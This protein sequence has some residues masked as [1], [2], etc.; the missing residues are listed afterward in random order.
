MLKIIVVDDE[1]LIRKGLVKV[2]SNFKTEFQVLGEATNGLEAMELIGREIPDVVITDVKMPH[3]D[4]VELVKE[5]ERHYP[6]IKKIVISGFGEFDYVR[7]T[8]RYGALDYLLKPLDDEQLISLLGKIT[9]FIE[10]DKKQRRAESNL[11]EKLNE[12]LPFLK[13]QFIFELI[14]TSK[15]N[16]DD[17]DQKL[18]LYEIKLNPGKY[19]V[20]I[21][22]LD[23]YRWICREAGVEATKGMLLK[24]KSCFDEVLGRCYEP[25]SCPFPGGQIY[26]IST[27]TAD[28]KFIQDVLKEGL[29]SLELNAPEIRVTLSI[30]PPCDDL[31]CLMKSYQQA[32]ALLRR[33]FYSEKSGIISFQSITKPTTNPDTKTDLFIDI[34]NNLERSLRNC[35]EVGDHQQVSVIFNDFSALFKKF[36]F[37]PL[38][39]VKLLIEVYVRLQS[40]YPE[41]SKSLIELYGLEDSYPKNLESFDTYDFLVQENIKLYTEVIKKI[42]EIRNRKDKRLVK[43]IKDYINEN[44]HEPISL[45]MIAENIYLSPSYISDLFKK[46]TGENI[47]DYLAKVRIEKAKILLKDLQIKGY[48]I[49]EM[50]GY[51]DPAYFSKVFKKVVGVSPNEYRSIVT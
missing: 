11:Q 51:K 45:N 5:L 36:Q 20:I 2:L 15:F 24:V 26:L 33:R 19:W 32:V 1:E 39:V 4:G 18:E 46:Q 31:L 12:G 16:K 23:N 48:E 3:M 17:V 28:P 27:P 41:F 43:E 37:D 7:E 21:A 42:V 9:S 14:T 22:S 6:E 30:G 49:G 25:I 13:E 50:V 40:S 44:Y 34:L 35:L 10:S 8:M 29:A 47:T 38:E